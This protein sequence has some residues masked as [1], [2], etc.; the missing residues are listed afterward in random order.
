MT[1]WQTEWTFRCDAQQAKYGIAR[2]H[3]ISIAVCILKMRAFSAAFY[4][5]DE[6]Q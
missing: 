5:A 4:M 2:W 6:E 3:A 1:F